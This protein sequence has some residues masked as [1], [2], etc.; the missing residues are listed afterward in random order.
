MALML[1]EQVRQCLFT[2]ITVSPEVMAHEDV[3]KR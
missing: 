2:F 1:P 3:L